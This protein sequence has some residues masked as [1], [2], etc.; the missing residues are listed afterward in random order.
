[1]LEDMEPAK[2]PLILVVEDALWDRELLVTVLEREGYEVA[3]AAGGAQA[4]DLAVR[5]KP[6]LILLDVLLPDLDGLAVCREL[7][8]DPATL[9]IPVIFLT[10]QSESGQILAGFEAGAVDYVTKPFRVLEML[11][12][13]H[14]HVELRRVQQEV[15][16]LRGILPTC[17]KCRK[18]RDEH[19]DWHPMEVY[20]AKRTDA[21][22]S[23]GFCPECIPLLF[24]ELDQ[25]SK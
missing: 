24:P 23:H 5:G 11:A 9:A 4:L 3:Q 22:F 15:K 1:M 19:G 8:A 14:V 25:D 16:T 6:D 21:M 18:I 17:A 12:R 20:I 13:V 10:G 7:K 2:R